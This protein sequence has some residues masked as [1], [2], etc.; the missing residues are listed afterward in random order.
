MAALEYSDA[1]LNVRAA[2]FGAS[3]MLYVE[4]DDDVIFWESI[5]S[6]FGR[7]GFKVES[8]GGVEEL[9][10]K[11]QK[12]ESQ[13]IDSVA[14][15]DA[16]FVKLDQASQPIRNVMVTYGHSIENSLITS[17]ALYKLAR[18]YG[19]IPEGQISEQDFDAWLSDLEFN[20]SGLIFYDA[21]NQINEMGIAV[22]SDNCTRFMTSQQSCSPSVQKIEEAMERHAQNL[23]LH[24]NMLAIKAVFD[25]SGHRAVDFMRGHFLATAAMKKVNRLVARNGA[26]KSV[27]NDSF[28]S[29]LMMGFD[30]VFDNNHPHY[31]Y[32][33][34]Q[35]SGV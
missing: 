1:A 17:R 34:D 14:A 3:K 32:Y 10:K 23:P 9:K 6:S 35:V 26:S 18:V 27:N 29:S 25:R 8:V 11:I 24:T 4:G 31:E 21:A 7:V 12:I 20:F 5:L 22:L 33:R 2:F 28:I 16:D 13:Q 30:Q 19:R 15:R